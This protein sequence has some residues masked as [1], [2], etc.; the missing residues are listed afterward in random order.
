MTATQTQLRRG[1]EAQCDIGTP[2]EGEVWVD[3]TNDRLRI[4]DAVTLGGIECPNVFDLQDGLF[5]S[6]TSV[7]G[8]NNLTL[9][10]DPPIT[11]YV[12][13]MELSFFA[14]NTNTGSMQIDAGDGSV[15]FEKASG[16]TI[17]AMVAG[18]IIAGAPYR[19]RFDGTKF[20]QVGSSA[21]V[22]QVTGADGITVSPTSGSPIVRTNTNNALG[23]GAVAFL[24]YTDSPAL[25]NGSTTSG[26]NL[27]PMTFVYNATFG[28]WQSTSGTTL[29][30]TWR[31]ISGNTLS[32]A[33]IGLFIRTA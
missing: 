30:G 26:A 18:D 11:S 24:R 8:T 21:G 5:T 22:S 32:S 28:L 14:A 7:S 4:G 29:S 25:T 15:A 1:T 9:V 16:G 23:V 20:V 33:G 31:N 19:A 10:F 13:G 3:T 6:A 17:T 27:I 12:T 2:V